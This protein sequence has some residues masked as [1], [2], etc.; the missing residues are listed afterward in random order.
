MLPEVLTGGTLE[1][2]INVNAEAGSVW[3]RWD[4]HFHT[5]S[6]FDYSFSAAT[7]QQLVDG[8]KADGISVVVVA[9][10]LCIDAERIESMRTL[11]GDDLAVFP[12]I[13]L[14]TNQGGKDSLHIIGI[15]PETISCEDLWTRVS[16]KL[17]LTKDDIKNHGGLQGYYVDFPTA[18]RTIHE[19]GGLV[20]VH[21][22]SKGNGIESI[23]NSPRHREY[24][25]ENTLREDVDILDVG[26][27]ADEIDYHKIVFPDIKHKL[28]IVVGSDCH[29]IRKYHEFAKPC[30]IK[31]DPT[32][33]GIQQVLRMPEERVCLKDE[34]DLL[35]SCRVNSTEFI[36]CVS[37][38]RDASVEL[39]ETWFGTTSVPLNPGMTAIIGNKGS[40]KSALA[41]I[42]ALLGNWGKSKDY[43]FLSTKRFRNGAKKARAFTSTMTWYDGNQTARNLM[44]DPLPGDQER[45]RFVGQEFLENVCNELVDIRGSQFQKEIERVVFSHVPEA[46]RLGCND[47]LQVIAKQTSSLEKRIDNLR[48]ELHSINEKIAELEIQAT[49][50]ARSALQKELLERVR[51]YKAQ[52]QLKPPPVSN[53]DESRSALPTDRKAVTEMVQKLTG[54]IRNL[55]TEIVAKKARE[56]EVAVLINVCDQLT[57]RLQDLSRS[58]AE[59][60]RQSSDQMKLL[61][62][63]LQGIVTLRADFAP[64]TTR[65]GALV[66]ERACIHEELD[67]EKEESLLGQRSGLLVQ[68]AELQQ[69]LDA[70]QKAY[71]KYLEDE[72]HWENRAADLLGDRD[73]EAL[74]TIRAAQKAL[75]Q[76]EL[77]PTEIARLRSE[78]AARVS[79]IYAS[80]SQIRS[81]YEGLYRPVQDFA[82]N[83]ELLR[84]S[85]PITFSVGITQ[86]EFADRFGSMIHHAHKGVFLG[87]SD[88]SQYLN[89][90]V[91]NANFSDYG[92]TLRF[93]DD[94]VLELAT[95]EKRTSGKALDATAV[96]RIRGQLKQGTTVVDMYDFLYGLSYLVARYDLRFDGRPLSEL[97]PGEKGSVLLIFYLLLDQSECPLVIDQPEGNLDNETVVKTLIPCVGEARK[98]RQVVLVTH[99]PNLAVVCDADEIIRASM[100]KDKTYAIKYVSGAIE[101]P[102]MNK[103][104]VDVLE[105]TERAFRNRDSAYIKDSQAD[106]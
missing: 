61:G 16:V 27:P 53:P 29:D 8:L 47:L 100:T 9:D 4:F 45:V 48:V 63:G 3:R 7:N 19:L 54:E 89:E 92:E 81:T 5:P 99:N 86:V 56:G 10:H 62:I 85:A 97:S 31:A 15:F 103:H 13:E 84:D 51:G 12:G 90:V 80:L 58:Y 6:S 79:D 91:Q 69:Q 57:Q 76:W 42:I 24:F 40:G 96:E 68:V 23:P 83:H 49:T 18:I 43:T 38:S 36:K 59:F 46:D 64:L 28:P 52:Y 88:A 55:E 20:S 35:T 34:P 33:E 2:G 21:A 11:A 66:S 95:G 60:I 82:S 74:G 78:R 77:L 17:F 25:K 93:A 102:T 39:D 101:N 22:G 98:H 87:D 105:G 70:P 65:R 44:D 37:I 67:P 1:G 75:K 30:W 26:K 71:Q 50:E 41:E 72:A 94:L 32:F 106:S 14:R 73:P 104:V